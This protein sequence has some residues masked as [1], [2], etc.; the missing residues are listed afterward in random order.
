VNIP[1][2]LTAFGTTAKAFST[3]DKMDQ[4]FRDNFPSNP[5]YWAFSSRMVKS[6]LKK[7]SNK[8]VKDPLEVMEYLKNRGNK[9]AVVQ[10]LHIIHG[11]EFDR[12]LF[13]KDSVDIRTSM[14]LPLLTSP[15]DYFETAAALEPY[16][17][18]DPNQATILVGHGT[19]HP[20]WASYAAFEDI[21]RKEHNCNIFTGVVED[22]PGMEYTLERVKN[23]GLEKVLIIPFMLVAGVHFKEDL[24]GK[25]DSWKA[26]FHK[27]NIEVSVL[28]HGIGEISKI[29]NIY[30][31]H[32]RDALDIIPLK[33]E[34]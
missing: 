28:D 20:A 11:H 15:L 27:N 24:T 31:R 30:C 32:I 5:I 13:L 26:L 25:D 21:M 16:I 1:V 19:D 3:Y 10:S 7:N 4:I 14:G 29:S 6:A 33:G 23:A 9:W 34:R 8:D 17:S 2:I 18:K 12:L 22:Y